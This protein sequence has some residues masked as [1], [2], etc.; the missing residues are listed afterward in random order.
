MIRVAVVED[1]PLLL[2]LLT[3]RLSTVQGLTVVGSYDTGNSA[4][5]RT[6]SLDVAI[7]DIDLGVGPDGIDVAR[8]WRARNQELGL[9]FMSNLTDPAVLLLAEQNNRG[10]LVYL[11][12]RA[13]TSITILTECIRAAAAGEVMVEESLA[14]SLPEAPRG[15][16]A[17]TP[18]QQRILRAIATGA[19]NKRIAED[20]GVSPKSV[21]NA[22]ASALRT[23][24]IDGTDADVNVR[25]LAALAY[26]RSAATG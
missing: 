1:E 18:H 15:L 25:V 24:G 13:A 10:G 3:E 21:E 14:H 9:V 17:L 22:T 4:V 8:I 2:E 16:G 26:L 5:A 11:H 19:S 6:D 12:K 20:L 7:L 23:L